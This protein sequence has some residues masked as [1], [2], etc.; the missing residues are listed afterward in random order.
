MITVTGGDFG[1]TLNA[2][3]LT[4]TNRVTL[5]GGLRADTLTG[6]AGNDTLNGG[7]GNDKLTGGGGNDTLTG[8]DGDDTLSGNAGID[9]LIGDAGNDTL[10]GGGGNDTLTGGDDNDTLTGGDGNDTLRGDAGNDT[11]NGGDGNDS[12][13]GN[14]GNDLLTGG[15]GLDAF[16][17]DTAL[18]AATNVDQIFD[19]S[20][21]DDK[22][23][24]SAAIFTAAGPVGTTLA[25]A[26][27]VIGAGRPT[28]ATGSSTTARPERSAMTRT[29]TGWRRRRN[30]PP[31]RRSR[32]DQQRFPDRVE[33][34]RGHPARKRESMAERCSV[35]LDP[36]FRGVTDLSGYSPR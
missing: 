31:S 20:S 11:L 23:L 30:S 10:N 26:A 4:G 17:F 29:A 12:L 6:G 34:R 21:V 27:F 13:A 1:N 22:V 14:T 7:G 32:P 8:G 18:N 2:S 28:P 33:A 25:A 35:A 36:R 5:T 24:L 16:L 9:S 19:F 3:A 15:L